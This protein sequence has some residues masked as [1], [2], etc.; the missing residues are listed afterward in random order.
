MSEYT[1]DPI[2]AT[3]T[4]PSSRTITFSSYGR[5]IC[6][7]GSPIDCADTIPADSF[8]SIT[9]RSNFSQIFWRTSWSR[10]LLSLR[11]WIFFESSVTTNRGS[12]RPI[13]LRPSMISCS[14][15]AR[16]GAFTGI[17]RGAS[18]S[19]SAAFA[20]GLLARA[21]G[22][23]F[24]RFGAGLGSTGA[25]PSFLRTFSASFF[26]DLHVHV[27]L[28]E[29]V[30]GHLLF[31]EPLLPRGL[32]AED[33]LQDVVD[34]DRAS[35]DAAGGIH[36]VLPELEL[37]DR[38]RRVPDGPVLLHLEVLQGVDQ[39]ALHVPRPRGTDGGIDEAF[40]SAHRVEEVLRR[41]EPAL[42]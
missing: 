2:E 4:R 15:G 40:A 31:A 21:A 12:Q 13:S 7:P 29:A 30:R 42:V 16:G 9:W 6:V 36:A 37:D 23:A 34:V 20:V 10:F 17:V 19:A 22:F 8:A 28:R 41:M 11:P 26:G 1:S 24:S 35:L 14:P 27:F 38:V 25:V 3:R 39:T 33:L 18:G 5:L 32:L